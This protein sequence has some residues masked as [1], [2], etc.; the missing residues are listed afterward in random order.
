MTDG[1]Q[2]Q[3]TLVAHQNMGDHAEQVR[4]A[5]LA[6]PDETVQNL[7]KRVMELGDYQKPW[8]APQPATAWIELRYVDDGTVVEVAF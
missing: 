2:I 6:E 5:H 4:T 1:L 3:V 7:V 8:R